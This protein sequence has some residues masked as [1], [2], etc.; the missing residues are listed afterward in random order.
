[1]T[2]FAESLSLG[3]ARDP[4]PILRE[5]LLAAFFVTLAFSVSASQSLLVLLILVALPWARTRSAGAET[6]LARGVRALWADTVTLRKNPLTPPFLWL[7]GLTLAS[8]ALSGDPGWSLWIARDTLRIATFYVVL[9]LTRDS[10]HA[11]RLW[12]GFLIVLTIMACYGL[13]Q[14]YLCGARPGALPPA[15]LDSICT[16]PSRVSGPFS[17][18]MTFGGVLL[19]GAIFFVAYLANVPWGRV[20]W[21]VPSGAITVAALAFTYSRNAWLGLVAGILGLVATARRAGL[22]A[23]TV[24]ALGLLAAAVSPATVVERAR[25]LAD[26]RDATFR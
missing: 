8:A 11:L 16:H 7:T 15:W 1:M 5:G 23:L 18:Y 9:R 3:R 14:A 22:I 26:P 13:S 10:S 4:G 17:I 12:Q 21:M 20:W 2:H 24:V 25:S 6:R 19:V